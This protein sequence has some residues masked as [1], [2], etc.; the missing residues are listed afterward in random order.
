VAEAVELTRE[1]LGEHGGIWELQR[2][3]SHFWQRNIHRAISKGL[4]AVLV[5]LD[6]GDQ[7]LSL[8]LIALASWLPEQR[9]VSEPKLEE[10]MRSKD[11][12][13]SS[14]ALLALARLGHD[15]TNAIL[16]MSD[17]FESKGERGLPVI[18]LACAEVLATKGNAGPK[19]RRALMKVAPDVARL[20]DPFSTTVAET[21]KLVS[22][23]L[24]W[25]KK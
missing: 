20:P 24:V 21:V 15:V 4:E 25:A 13:L 19:A 9:A 2:L 12:L 5:G 23:K 6:A 17:E 1:R 18:Y 8:E 7:A 14:A 16:V 3:F 10:A 22:A 11:R